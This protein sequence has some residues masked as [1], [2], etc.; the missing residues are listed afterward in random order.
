MNFRKSITML[1]IVGLFVAGPSLVPVR[2]AVGVPGF[3]PADSALASQLQLAAPAT[4]VAT[5][6]A[7]IVVGAGIVSLFVNGVLVDV[8][9]CRELTQAEAMQSLFLPLVGIA[10]NQHANKCHR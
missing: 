3:V 10:L 6:W 8:T 5:P 2:P 4:H 7:P 1:G 9:Q